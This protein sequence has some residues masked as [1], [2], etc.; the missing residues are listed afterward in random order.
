MH[1][2]PNNPQTPE[3][4]YP[5]HGLPGQDK[6]PMNHLREGKMEMAY[7]LCFLFFFFVM[8]TNDFELNCVLRH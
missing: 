4:E 2:A 5:L 1:R 8:Q 3:T 6:R 7:Y